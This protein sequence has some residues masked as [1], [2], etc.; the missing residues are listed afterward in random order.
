MNVGRGKVEGMVKRLEGGRRGEERVVECGVGVGVR[1]RV[2]DWRW[3]GGDGDW[4]LVD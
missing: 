2:V 3:D 4:M 1:E